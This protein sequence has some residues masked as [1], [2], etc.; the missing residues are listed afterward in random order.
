MKHLLT[1]VLFCVLFVSAYTQ[2]PVRVFATQKVENQLL[3]EELRHKKDTIFVQRKKEIEKLINQVSEPKLDQE[4]IIPVVFHIFYVPGSPYPREKE[5]YY[6]LEALNRD[7]GGTITSSNN[8]KKNETY[9]KERFEQRHSKE[10]KL[11]FCLAKDI[12]IKGEIQSSI[13]YAQTKI[14]TWHTN[15]AMKSTKTNGI[16]PWDT[17]LYLNI[18]VVQM[19]KDTC[20]F[21]Q[22]PG[23][24][25]SSDGIVIDYNYFGQLGGP[26]LDKYYNQGKTLTHLVGSYLGLY[27]LWNEDNPCADDFVDDTPIH[28]GPNSGKHTYKHFSTCNENLVE[29]TMNFMDNSDDTELFMFTEGQKRRMYSVLSKNGIRNKL[30]EGSSKCQESSALTEQL[31]LEQINAKNLPKKDPS[32]VLVFPNPASSSVNIQIDVP[33]GEGYNMLIYSQFGQVVYEQKGDMGGSHQFTL[34]TG[35]WPAGLYY[36][37]VLNGTRRFTEK[38]IISQK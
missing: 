22:M 14:E 8:S 5:V 2:R 7:F 12:K 32:R 36:I 13:N 31:T 26:F 24:P 1:L 19:A 10:V 20:G 18:W 33:L 34:D 21:A 4:I 35:R 16:D 28:N 9:V 25:A 11:K 37:H 15:N 27:E 30:G 6:Q 38:L 17:E 29:M 3:Q 23:G